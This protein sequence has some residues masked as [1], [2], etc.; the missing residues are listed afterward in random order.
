MSQRTRAIVGFWI[1][2]IP[3]IG[4]FCWISVNIAK[5]IA[6]PTAPKYDWTSEGWANAYIPFWIIQIIG[7]LC[8]TVSISIS[9]FVK[10]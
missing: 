8:Q 7:Y 2:T 6:M 5:F 3:S 1:F 4:M 9:H 10:V